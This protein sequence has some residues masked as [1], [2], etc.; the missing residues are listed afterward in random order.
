M[1]FAIRRLQDDKR[2]TLMAHFLA[3]PQHDRSLRFGVSLASTVIAAYVDGI[4]FARDGVFGVQDDQLALVGVAHVAIEDDRAEL[5]LSV[6][7]VHRRCGVG[8]ALFDAAVAHAS[9]CR[10]PTLF[11]HC[12]TGNAAIMRIAQRFGMD[13]IT[14]GGEAAAHIQLQ[15]RS[16]KGNRCAIQPI[17]IA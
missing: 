14:G 4:D 12:R 16:V 7:P 1:S 6:L 13:I 5:G 11:M 3:L 9:R 10:I 8:S 2:A 17:S 15:P